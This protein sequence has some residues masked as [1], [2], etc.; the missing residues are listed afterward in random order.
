MPAR[1]LQDGMVASNEERKQ[2]KVTR[3]KVVRAIVWIAGILLV[4]LF[5]P[6]LVATVWVPSCSTC[7]ND[8]A[9]VEQT[10]ES[11]HAQIECTVCHGGKSGSDALAFR[12]RV[13]YQMTLRII[14]AAPKDLAF[15]SNDACDSCHANVYTKT[16]VSNGI[17][18]QH[19]A[20]APQKSSSCLDCHST[21]AHGEATIWPDQ[22]DMIACLECHAQEG[23]SSEAGCDFCH[24]GDYDAPA[25]T[26]GTA[27]KSTHGTEWEQTHGMG[28]LKT[29]TACHP[30]DYCAQCHGKGVPHP[31]NF[32]MSHGPIA[33]Q[34]DSKCL[35]CHTS[36]K[37]FC[38]R[39]HGLPMPHSSNFLPTHSK[40]VESKGDANCYNCHSKGDCDVCH[41]A[42]IHPGGAL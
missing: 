39:C 13:A 28:D 6:G 29:C 23:V 9:F 17:K 34:D 25:P 20:C 18:I 5:V 3:D 27:F 22:Y 16:T 33:R 42:H 41:A 31:D 35:E 32:V 19:D 14:P 10:K 15:V 11:A 26:A 1:G 4:L 36:Q 30:S 24:A 40:Y 21:V 12:E 38:D 37:L 2:N 8:A 7:H